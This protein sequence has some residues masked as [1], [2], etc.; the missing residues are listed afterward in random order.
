MIQ[1][2]RLHVDLTGTA[3]RAVARRAQVLRPGELTRLLSLD[4]GIPPHVAPSLD[5]CI[6]L[7]DERWAVGRRG[8]G[9]TVWRIVDAEA[10][11]RFGHPA[12]MW[13][14]DRWFDLGV[15]E[16]EPLA[17]PPVLPLRQLMRF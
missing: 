11:A 5:R 2:P 6:P 4:T 7:A 3:P 15:A 9:T 16:D 10:S 12:W 17:V 1:V 14:K 13:T 8:E